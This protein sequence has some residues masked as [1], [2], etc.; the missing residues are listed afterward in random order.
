MY[1][2]LCR[3]ACP[4]TSWVGILRSIFTIVFDSF[5]N[6]C[7]VSGRTNL[8]CLYS[9]ASDHSWLKF[10]TTVVYNENITFIFDSK[11]SVSIFLPKYNVFY[12]LTVV[13]QPL[14]SRYLFF[15]TM[16]FAAPPGQEQTKCLKYLIVAQ[17]IVIRLQTFMS[18]PSTCHSA[19]QKIFDH[20][21]ILF[22]TNWP[23]ILPCLM[24]VSLKASYVKKINTAVVPF[25]LPK[26]LDQPMQYCLHETPSLSEYCLLFYVHP[27]YAQKPT[28]PKLC[29]FSLLQSMIKH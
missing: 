11:D 26:Q 1:L 9:V 21:Q 18:S 14:A 17:P 12:L 19:Y 20:S 6:L 27:N 10:L 13:L 29:S 2:C 15:V 24:L 16:H 4:V 8:F 25:S 5:R 23:V 7:C 22:S 3:L 28:F